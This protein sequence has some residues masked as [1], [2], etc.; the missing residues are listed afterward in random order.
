MM[1]GS[2]KDTLKT[3]VMNIH[4]LNCKSI[5]FKLINLIIFSYSSIMEVFAHMLYAISGN[6]DTIGY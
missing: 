2:T 3:I 4:N 6:L 5:I 1:H